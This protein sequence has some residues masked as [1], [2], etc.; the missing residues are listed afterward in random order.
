[1]NG[2][3]PLAQAQGF[4]AAAPGPPDAREFILDFIASHEDA[5]T[6]A[7][8]DGHLTGSALVIDRS[9]RCALLMHHR[10]LDKWLQMG[11]HADGDGD[12]AR[13]ALREATE[14]SGL[15]ELMLASTTPVDLDVHRVEPPGEVPHLHLDVRFLVVAPPGSD[16][17]ANHESRELRWVAL[18]DLAAWPEDGMRRLAEAGRSL[19]A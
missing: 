9:R 8:A 18:D 15:A 10:K 1:M 3:S 11:G 2:G 16:P 19:V 5:L 7:C 14:E 13:V 6:R 12:L 4:V 17:I